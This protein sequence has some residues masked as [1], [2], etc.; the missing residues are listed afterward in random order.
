MTRRT[1]L[2]AA[3]RASRARGDLL[4]QN[5]AVVAEAELICAV[6]DYRAFGGACGRASC[7][8]VGWGRGGG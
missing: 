6:A 1:L 7:G 2:D 4:P 5:V 3:V 8:A